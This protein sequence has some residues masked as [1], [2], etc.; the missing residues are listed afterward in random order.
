MESFNERVIHSFLSSFLSFFHSFR[1]KANQSDMLID[2]SSEASPVSKRL[3]DDSSSGDG[4]I[5]FR[6]SSSRFTYL[7]VCAFGSMCKTTEKP[8]RLYSR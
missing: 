5:H 4:T 6:R 2:C 1:S 8:F 7:V 3:P